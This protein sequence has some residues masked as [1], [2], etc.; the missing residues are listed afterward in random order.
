MRSSTQDTRGERQD[1]EERH[2]MERNT[3]MREV[4]GS[5]EGKE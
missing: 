5:E 4:K 1:R 2:K 3:A